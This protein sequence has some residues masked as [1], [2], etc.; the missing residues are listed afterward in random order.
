MGVD[1][2]DLDSQ[3]Y[4]PIIVVDESDGEEEAKE[5]HATKHTE[6]KDTSAPQ[7]PSPRK[8]ELEKNKDEAEVALLSAQ[9]SFPNVAQLIEL[10]VKSLQPPKFSKILYAHDFNSSLPT[11]LKEL[12]SKFNELNGKVKE[13]KKH[14]HD[15]EIE[16]PR[17]LK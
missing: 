7:P 12:P 2:M 1:F 5:I 14:V 6:S 3:E 4:D 10:L 13:L 9:P 15:L 8:L 17:D 16:L 11:E